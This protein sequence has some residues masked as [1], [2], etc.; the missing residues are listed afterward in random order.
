MPWGFKRKIFAVP[1]LMNI[2]IIGGL[3]W[4]ISVIGPYYMNICFS[5]MGRYNE[6]T[7][8]TANTP[9]EDMGREILR[10][11]LVFMV[12]LIIYA[13]IWP[14]PRNFFAGQRDGNPV[15][16]RFGI[17]FRDKEI[18]VRRSRK[19]DRDIGDILDNEN[20]NQLLFENV[21]KAVDPAWMHEKT[22][23]LMLNREWDLDWKAM[24][25]A[26]KLVDTKSIPLDEFKTTV[27]VH[28]ADFG[29]L[30]IEATDAGGSAEEEKGR[31]KIVYFKEEL[32]AMGKENLFFRWIEL[33]QY[34]S[35]QPGGF[36]PDRQMKT[37]SKAKEMFEA[38]GIDFDKLWAKV[39]GM[40]G[41]PGM[42]QV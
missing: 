14:W 30:V 28:T 34:E 15:S 32:T 3:I 8:D 41:M 29:W 21:R 18:I 13:F 25:R 42:D 40:D 26:T 6:T 38:Q 16:W 10:R 39:G 36:G 31:R 5:L 24:V 1:V 37:M 27:L 19:W 23:Y 11:T 33:V 17:G 20:G 22:G 35:S 2:A 12:D 4:R 7:I 9:W